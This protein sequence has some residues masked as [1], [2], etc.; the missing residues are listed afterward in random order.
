MYENWNENAVN[1]YAELK[2]SGVQTMIF[3]AREK[4][5]SANG[6]RERRIFFYQS[7]VQSKTVEILSASFQP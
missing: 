2:N 7:L 1:A 4:D 5:S 6:S 3:F